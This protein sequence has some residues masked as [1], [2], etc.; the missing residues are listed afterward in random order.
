[1]IHD[2][3]EKKVYLGSF[4]SNS[5]QSHVMHLENVELL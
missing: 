5:L 1:M 4:E 2:W 3:V